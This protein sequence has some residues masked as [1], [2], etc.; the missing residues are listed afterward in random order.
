[1]KL[2]R[3]IRTK[4]IVGTI[5]EWIKDLHCCYLNCSI[6][7]KMKF[8]IENTDQIYCE[9]HALLTENSIE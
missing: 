5:D 1:M 6:D 2:E 3:L 4:E 9:H 7:A 8:L